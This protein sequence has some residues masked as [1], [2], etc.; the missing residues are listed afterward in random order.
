MGELADTGP[1]RAAAGPGNLRWPL[2]RH[3]IEGA[4]IRRGSPR[5]RIS[6]TAPPPVSRVFY[7]VLLRDD[8]HVCLS[9][10]SI[11]LER[12]SYICAISGISSSNIRQPVDVFAMS[13]GP[14]RRAPSVRERHESGTDGGQVCEVR[15]P[16]ARPDPYVL[17]VVVFLFLRSPSKYEMGRWIFTKIEH[18]CALSTEA[19]SL[20]G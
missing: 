3:L 11:I 18:L 8:K 9:S 1:A 5:L 10:S 17:I 6:R 4:V 12:L 13:D 7:S 15:G 20:V 2:M 14:S 16:V 19:E